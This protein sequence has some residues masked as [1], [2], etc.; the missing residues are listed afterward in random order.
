[1]LFQH[2][3]RFFISDKNVLALPILKMLLTS[4]K[5]ENLYNHIVIKGMFSASYPFVFLIHSITFLTVADM[6]A[7]A[8]LMSISMELPY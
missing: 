2:M 7:K 6:S 3:L 4:I 5:F 8:S 1:M